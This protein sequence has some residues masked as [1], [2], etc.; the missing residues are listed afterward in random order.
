MLLQILLIM[1]GCTGFMVLAFYI[2]ILVH[3]IGHV[4]AGR[5]AGMEFK[6]VLVGNLAV[7]KEADGRLVPFWLGRIWAGG[8]TH[9]VLPDTLDARSR[10]RRFILGGPVASLLWCAFT[11]ALSFAG[12]MLLKEP[13]SPGANI[14]V[15]SSAMLAAVSILILPG[16]LS[17]KPVRGIPTDVCLLN[18]LRE[19]G[20]GSNRLIAMTQLDRSIR[21]GQRER[22]WPPELIADALEVRDGGPEEMQACTLAY[23][24]YT[25]IGD[26]QTAEEVLERAFALRP[27]KDR[28]A[29]LAGQ[30]VIYLKAFTLARAGNPLAAQDVLKEVKKPLEFLDGNR[31]FTLAAIALAEGKGAEASAHLKAARVA[32][33]QMAK[34]FPSNQEAAMELLDKL[35]GEA[36]ALVPVT[37]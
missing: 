30:S 5:R 11:I 29:G 25:D 35:Q 24:H 21:L 32:L 3:E 23:Y 26:L 28:D 14:A 10:Y 2:A 31:A 13:R 12:A 6:S 15:T 8:F 4:V 20:A 37:P 16:T 33:G 34:L 17:A 19:E 18:R 1:V 22:D 36:K 27:K 9:M 7:R